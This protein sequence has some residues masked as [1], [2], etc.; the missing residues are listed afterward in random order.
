MKQIG[1][2]PKPF[3]L[4]SGRVSPV[5]LFHSTPQAERSIMKMTSWN[6][7]CHILRLLW[8]PR[9]TGALPSVTCLLLFLLIF[10]VILL[11]LLP[12]YSRFHYLVVVHSVE[13][14]SIPNIA[15]TWL[16]LN[17]VKLT[18]VHGPPVYYC[19][20]HKT[21]KMTSCGKYDHLSMLAISKF[22]IKW[23]R[24]NIIFM[25]NQIFNLS[26]NFFLKSL[27]SEPALLHLGWPHFLVRIFKRGDEH[28]LVYISHESLKI[29]R[30]K[31]NRSTELFLNV[32]LL[33]SE[34][35]L[36]L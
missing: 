5:S 24:I 26:W 19:C 27:F 1:C 33:F 6:L 10:H 28:G 29:C 11:H 2:P 32:D 17:L 23:I 22:W 8:T 3:Q 15:L 9:L 12:L 20:H 13:S 35:L 4:V 7:K 14:P 36:S 30:P 25:I 34:L 16:K 21:A 18:S 31:W